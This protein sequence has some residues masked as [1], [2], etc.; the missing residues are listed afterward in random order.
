MSTITRFVQQE[1]G[2][3]ANNI[4]AEIDKRFEDLAK[5]QL[6]RFASV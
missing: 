3:A 1:L 2:T 4:L 6:L 5:I